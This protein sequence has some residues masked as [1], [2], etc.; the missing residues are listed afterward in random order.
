MTGRELFASYAFPPN[1]LGY[2]GPADTTQAELASHA[3]EF[4][5]AWPYLQAIADAAGIADPLDD[6]VVR[7]YWVGGPL[8]AK[9]DPDE[10]VTC[11]KSAF[12]GQ[13]TG[14][15][16]DIAAGNPLAHHSFHVFVVYPWVR[17][18]G[19]DPATPVRVMQACRV[20][21][22]TVESVDDEY[23]VVTSQPLVFDGGALGLAAAEQERVRWRK[24]DTTL[25]PP[26][27]PGDIVAAHWDWICATITDME[28]DALADATKQT[29]DLV[30]SN[31]F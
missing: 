18:L 27:A 31:R 10:L 7:N 9:V 29:L 17:F 24:D 25:A 26:L 30:N 13:V 4:D 5:G 16:D 1:E 28:R 15:L 2:C 3:K 19:R 23:A 6:D 22:A 20:R 12:T 14:M 8:L 11:L 21:W